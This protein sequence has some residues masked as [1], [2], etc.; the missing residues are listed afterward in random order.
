MTFLEKE[1]LGNSGSLIEL[2][3]IPEQQNATKIDEAELPLNID[4]QPIRRSG[5]Q[6]H[7]PERYYSFL[8]DRDVENCV[9]DNTEPTSYLQAIQ[10]PDSRK[11]RDAMKS[12]IDY[13]HTNKVWTL[14]DVPEGIKPI[15]SKWIFKKKISADGKEVTFKA[16][17]VVKGFCQKAGIDYDETFS[18]VAM[19]KSIRILLA[20]AAFYD[21]EI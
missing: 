7:P 21:Y 19:L 6:S 11:W 2:E 20:I 9:M 18:P 8:I 1:F 13:M 15:G 17:L 12:E 4:T 3:E 10:S 14:E 16:I 5:R